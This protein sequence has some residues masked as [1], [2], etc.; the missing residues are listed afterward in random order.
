ME[1]LLHHVPG[2]DG[3]LGCPLLLLQVTRFSCGGFTFALGLNHTMSDGVGLVQ[4]LN[5]I[6][7]FAQGN[8]LTTPS[9]L[10]VWQREVLSAR[11]LPR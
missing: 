9:V 2:S 5:A 11:K 1:E 10:P 7:E 8:G 3:F 4:F 6:A